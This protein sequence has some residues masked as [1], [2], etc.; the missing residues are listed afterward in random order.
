MENKEEVTINVHKE[1]T[2]NWLNKK[3]NL[4]FVLLFITVVV[5]R[6]YFYTMTKN[7]ALWWDESDYMATAKS[8]AGLGHYN[9]EA[10]R[11]PTFSLFVSIFFRLGLTEQT[12]RFIVLYISSLILIYFFYYLLKEMYAD[13]RIALISTLIFSVLWEHLFYSNRFHTENFSLIFQFLS[14]IVLVKSYLKK[15]K[16]LFIS[17][18]YSLVSVIILAVISVLFR[19]GSLMFAVGLVLFLIL[20][21]GDLIFRN[22]KNTT[23]TLI[24][25][26]I[27]TIL[28]FTFI[29]KI[30]SPFVTYYYNLDRPINYVHLTVFKGYYQPINPSLPN[31]LYYLFLLGTVIALAKMFLSYDKFKKLKPDKEFLEFKSDLLNFLLI[32][33]LLIS[34]IFFI[35]A[36]DYEFRWFFPLLPGMLAFTSKGIIDF[37]STIGE[38]L[39]NKKI[40]TILIVAFSL[41][42]F[43]TQ[44]AHANM[45]IN[46]K[47]DSYSQVKDSGIWIKEHSNNNDVIVSA[48]VPQH[49]YYTERKVYTFAF[50]NSSNNTEEYF[51]DKLKEIKPRYVAVSIFEP[52]FTPQWAYTW[53]QKHNE[54]VVP[55]KVY[56]AD[57]QQT[58]PILI[59]YEIKNKFI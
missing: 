59:V 36:Q 45:I 9:L 23:Y 34:L 53:G 52:V 8:L 1:K 4:V 54:T 7:Q 18:K 50:D 26:A 16:F 43:Y 6:F 32:I 27:L 33:C 56:F 57:Q 44:L 28:F 55:V 46:A 40:T 51:N 37:S 24:F 58:Q 41:F 47:V 17:S 48:S 30:H 13:K 21:K 19:P 5:I 31:L 25:F 22:K 20:L 42:G 14:L 15:E 39:S 29:G 2:K 49:S 12:I 10:I 38:K 3:E 35:R 11:L